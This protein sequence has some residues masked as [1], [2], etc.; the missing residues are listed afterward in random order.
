MEWLA[1]EKEDADFCLARFVEGGVRKEFCGLKQ[2]PISDSAA[3]EVSG[4]Q[5]RTPTVADS[6]RVLFGLGDPVWK[7]NR[8][9]TGGG[10]T[11]ASYVPDAERLVRVEPKDFEG[12]FVS[13]RGSSRGIAKRCSLAFLADGCCGS[14]SKACLTLFRLADDEGREFSLRLVVVGIR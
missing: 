1:T 14:S 4:L 10:V 6:E 9:P 13:E 5:S 2:A 7:P 8:S 12:V 11:E 3:Q